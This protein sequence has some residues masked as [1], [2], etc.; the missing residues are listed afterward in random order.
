[1][2]GFAGLR[3]LRPHDAG[4]L[5]DFQYLHDRVGRDLAP[6]KIDNTMLRHGLFVVL[7]I[8]TVDKVPCVINRCSDVA[9]LEADYCCELCNAPKVTFRLLGN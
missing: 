5:H 2:V 8:S 1:M 6:E 3:D 7:I 4:P 9:D